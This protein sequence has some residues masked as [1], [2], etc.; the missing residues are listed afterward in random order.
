MGYNAIMKG[1]ILAIAFAL[2]LGA[3]AQTAQPAQPAATPQATPSPM[4]G[5]PSAAVPRMPRAEF[6]K[7]LDADK[8]LAIDVRD[9]NS[10]RAGHIPGAILTPYAEIEQ[11]IL[12]LKASKKPIVAYC[13]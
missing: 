7:L 3:A 11:H 8:I 1:L 13:A 10:Y 6:K 12:T 5:D 9:I 2:P 4:P